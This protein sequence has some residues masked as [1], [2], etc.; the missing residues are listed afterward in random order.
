MTIISSFDGSWLVPGQLPSVEAIEQDLTSVIWQPLHRAIVG[1]NA[2]ISGASRDTGNVGFTDVLRPGLLLTKNADGDFIEWGSVVSK[3]VD[4]IQGVLLMSLK[5]TRNGVNTDR[6]IGHILLGGFVKCKG[7]IVP[8]TAAAGILGNADEALIRKKMLFNFTFDDD[9]T[10]SLAS[11]LW[12]ADDRVDG[13]IAAVQ[14][15]L[16]GAGAVNVTSYFT[17]WTTTGINAA[18][19]ANGTF[20]GQKKL[21]QM[22]VDGGDGTLTPAN[23]A[24]GNTIV[25]SNIGDRVL[26]EWNGIDW[27]VVE[28][29]NVASG[30]S[31]TPVLA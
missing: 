1:A 16:S 2:K 19:L 12:R 21:I 4:P 29:C 10:K 22:V 18:T 28:R 31:T 25:F 20:V 13:I 23:L 26:L 7:I 15:S 24:D 30:A 5:V 3:A 14:Q 17:A 9:Q 6:F 8:G 11:E 27:V